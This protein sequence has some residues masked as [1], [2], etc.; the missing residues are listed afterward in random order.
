MYFNGLYGS[1]F[2]SRK[3]FAGRG[4]VGANFAREGVAKLSR[5][6]R[7]RASDTAENRCRALL[8]IERR[9]REEGNGKRER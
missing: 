2:G 8:A 9:G 6:K 7:L 4:T 3:G 1:A 5:H